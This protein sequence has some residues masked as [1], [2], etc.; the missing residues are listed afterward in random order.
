[1]LEPFHGSNHIA[2]VVI[3]D[4]PKVRAGTAEDSLNLHRCRR[5]HMGPRVAASPRPRMTGVERENRWFKWSR[6]RNRSSRWA[7][8]LTRQ[9]SVG[10][11][12]WGAAR[13][14]GSSP[15]TNV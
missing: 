6:P 14:R 9:S 11:W 7:Y 5:P 4:A 3:P 8:V 1:M 15:E 10:S 12:R 13:L 2:N